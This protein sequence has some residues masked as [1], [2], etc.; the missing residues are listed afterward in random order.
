M[1]IHEPI[2]KQRDKEPTASSPLLLLTSALLPPW[3]PLSVTVTP[4]YSLRYQIQGTISL[5]SS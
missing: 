3:R 1:E 2:H 4:P 5:R